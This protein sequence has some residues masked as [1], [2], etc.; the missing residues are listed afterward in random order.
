MQER[1]EFDLTDATSKFM[2]SFSTLMCA[3]DF[4]EAWNCHSIPGNLF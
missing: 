1:R 2:V 3:A 4:V